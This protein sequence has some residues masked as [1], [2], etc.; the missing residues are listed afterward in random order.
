[1]RRCFQFLII[2]MFFF[3]P[4]I[5]FGYEVFLPHITGTGGFW[6]NYL[7]VNNNEDAAQSF[8][9]TLYDGGAQIFQQNFSVVGL[10][11]SIINLKDLA[12]TIAAGCGMCHLPFGKACT[13][14]FHTKRRPG[15][16]LRNSG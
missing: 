11:Q 9:I 16:A 2:I 3:I 6:R 7:Q 5:S 15:V 12:P 10:S 8:T 14:G 1:M 4:A 13:S